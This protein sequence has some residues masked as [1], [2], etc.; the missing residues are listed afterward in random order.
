MGTCPGSVTAE[1]AVK[2]SNKLGTWW[3]DDSNTVPEYSF[4][5]GLEVPSTGPISLLSHDC[6][7]D[8]TP[9]CTTRL[10]RYGKLLGEALHLIHS[11]IDGDFYRY[12]GQ[13]VPVFIKLMCIMKY[14]LLGT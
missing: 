9:G 13:Y 3:Q 14:S 4:C 10:S 6:R 1:S 11:C 8:E 5:K 12:L 2:F 7:L